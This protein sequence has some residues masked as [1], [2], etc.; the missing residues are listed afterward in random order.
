MLSWYKLELRHGK[1]LSVEYLGGLYQGKEQQ[2]ETDRSEAINARLPAFSNSCPALVAFRR[3]R[4]S[5]TTGHATNAT[6]PSTPS[7]LAFASAGPPMI[8]ADTWLESSEDTRR[9]TPETLRRNDRPSREVSLA[10]R[11]DIGLGNMVDRRVVCG[12][13]ERPS[14]RR[15][16]AEGRCSLRHPVGT[17]QRLRARRSGG[18]RPSSRRTCADHPRGATPGAK[19]PAFQRVPGLHGDVAIPEVPVLAEPRRQPFLPYARHK[20]QDGAGTSAVV[21]PRY[22]PQPVVER[23]AT[24]GQALATTPKLRP[25]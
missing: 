24:Q 11:R 15:A 25:S 4:A 22:G 1:P 2:R 19:V 16:E 8:Q 17:R 23:P 12:K 14:H 6:L 7:S 3:R 10:E 13:V 20:D 9:T 5:P 21:V 18:A